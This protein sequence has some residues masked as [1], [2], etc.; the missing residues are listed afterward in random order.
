MEIIV[1]FT[2]SFLFG[3]RSF[4]LFI[5]RAGVSH[6]WVLWRSLENYLL[7]ILIKPRRVR[8]LSSTLSHKEWALTSTNSNSIR[9]SWQIS[10]FSNFIISTRFFFNIF[11]NSNQ[12]SPLSIIIISLNLASLRV[13]FRR[14]VNINFENTFET[15]NFLSTTVFKLKRIFLWTRFFFKRFYYTFELFTR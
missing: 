1:N 4:S 8:D 9:N 11:F 3:K 7:S 6:E 5:A 15:V 12:L 2:F 13:R 14:L 10:S